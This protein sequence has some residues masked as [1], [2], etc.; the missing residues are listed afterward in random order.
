MIISILLLIQHVRR[1][2]ESQGN[3]RALTAT[4]AKLQYIRAWEALPEHGAS[5]FLRSFAKFV[6][7]G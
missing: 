3:A 6:Q 1:I 2:G 5:T 7:F 4:E